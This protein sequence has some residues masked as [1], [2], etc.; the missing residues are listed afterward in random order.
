VEGRAGVCPPAGKIPQYAKVKRL[1]SLK[2][3]KTKG[4]K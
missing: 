4:K 2:S 3:Q 1:K